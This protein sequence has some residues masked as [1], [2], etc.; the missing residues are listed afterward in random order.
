MKVLLIDVNCK[1]SSTGKIVY[2][3]YTYFNTHN[4]IASVCYGRGKKINEKNIYKFGIDIETYL[5]AF[6][7]RVTGYN[8]CFSYFST[9]R[10]IKYID[11]FK[12]DI[13]HIHELHA[14]FVNIK[15]LIEYIKRKKI[16]V[17]WTFHCEYMYTGKC[18]YAYDCEKWKKE[19]CKCPA[20]KDY[21]KSLFFDKTKKMFNNKKQMLLDLDFTIITPS[22]WL[23]NRVRQSFLKNKKILVIHNGIDT[24]KIFY[25]RNKKEIDYLYDKYRI[26]KT[27]KLIISVAPNIMSKIKGGKTVL[28][29]AKEMNEFQFILVGTTETKKYSNNVLLIKK[30]NDQNELARL[31]SLS[32]LFLICSKKENFPTT[33]IEAMSCG[34]PVVGIDEGGTKETVPNPYGLFVKNNISELKNAI[35]YQINKN[36][37]KDCVSNMAVKLYS[38]DVYGGRIKKI[39]LEFQ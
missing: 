5:H 16:P 21:P 14:Y 3:L 18:G 2:D 17:I 13:I 31:Y 6:L 4:N 34:L 15:T 20:L 35:Y 38:K 28:E 26:D 32:D 22:E 10:L 9:K 36:F 25:I 8:G 30:I 23:A 29:I 12:P 39:M 1:N 11:N 33:C 7:S 19:C 37:N 27:K 24:D